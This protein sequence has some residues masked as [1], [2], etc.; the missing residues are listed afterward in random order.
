[1]SPDS[2]PSPDRIDAGKPIEPKTPT[3]SEPGTEFRTFMEQ[4]GTGAPN[5]SQTGPASPM[6]MASTNMP[7]VAP[8][9]DTLTV[10]SKNMQDS[11]GNLKNQLKTPN[12]TLK[13]SQAHLLRNK[14]GDANDYIRG[15]ANKLGV[16]TPP[17][18]GPKHPG[19]TEKLMAYINDGQ[20][21]MVSIQQKLDDMM[22]SG[23]E[24]KPADM[25]LVQ[26][27]MGQAQQEL[28][29]SSTVLGKVVDAL[30]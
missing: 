22:S 2:T 19:V 30:K 18:K 24:L 4:P 7:G 6:Q 13:R 11:L 14:L 28:E 15:A 17:M 3:R 16:D 26:I 27:K 29:Y 25:M 1:M 5:V 23:T 20:E 8:S 12:L 10:Q 9:F 21:K